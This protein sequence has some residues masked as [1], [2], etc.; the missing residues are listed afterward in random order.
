MCRV[1]LLS[2]PV[3]HFGSVSPHIEPAVSSSP[4]K[5]LGIGANLT[6]GRPIETKLGI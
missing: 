3:S 5:L 2:L 6:H 4:T 1:V